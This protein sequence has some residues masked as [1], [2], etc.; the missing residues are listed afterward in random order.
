MHMY[1]AESAR[2]TPVKISCKN[3]VVGGGIAGV[4]AALSAA[5]AGTNVVLIEREYALGGLATLGLITHYLPLCDG[6]GHQVTFGLAEELMRVSM[7][8]DVEQDPFGAWREQLNQKNPEQAKRLICEF[9]PQVFAILVERLLVEAGVTILYGS[10]VC[11]VQKECGRIS[12]L[13]C[14]SREGRWAVLADNIIDCSGD[15]VV[16]QCAGAET[17]LFQQKNILASWYATTRDGMY[18]IQ[19]LGAADIP[20]EYKTEAQRQEDSK[21]KRRYS[22]VT[23]ME[24]SSFIL[25]AHEAIL[26]DY[27]KKGTPSLQYRLATI[28]T[29]PEIRMTRKAVGVSTL[30]EDESAVFSDSIGLITNWKRR[31]PIYEVPFSCMCVP[32]FRNLLVAGRCISVSD[33]MWDVTR[34]IPPCAVTG[35]AA[36]LAAAIETDFSKICISSLQEKLHLRGIAIH[37]DELGIK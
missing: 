6:Y 8:L 30:N 37:K 15:A 5:R 1:V 32:K 20:D 35:E 17:K 16:C 23:T 14:E 22:G 13:L 10:G 31:G 12:A 21:T 26:E 29:I 18:S 36:G 11:G 2:N 19:P 7:S 34:V 3:A 28:P 25:A 27:L 4:A 33:T 24:L 9:D